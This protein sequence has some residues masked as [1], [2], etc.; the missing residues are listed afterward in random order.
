MDKTSISAVS[1]ACEIVGGKSA[2]ARAVGVKP[3]TVAQWCSGERPVPPGKCIGIE[4]ATK[5]SVR[6]EQILPELDWG[7]IRGSARAVAE[8]A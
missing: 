4:K 8:A 5:R 7:F 3:A 6:V 1:R 2:L